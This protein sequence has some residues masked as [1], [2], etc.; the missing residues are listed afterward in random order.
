MTSKTRA[1]LATLCTLIAISFT[2]PTTTFAQDEEGTGDALAL[3]EA[4]NNDARRH[5]YQKAILKYKKV[6][7]LVPDQYPSVYYNLAEILRFQNTCSEAIILYRRY[8]EMVPKTRDKPQIT[9][10]IAGCSKTLKFARLTIT[11]EGDDYPLIHI[12]GIPMK[13]GKTIETDVSVGK[14][15]VYITAYD[16]ESYK[17]VISVGDDGLEHTAKLVEKLFHGELVLTA[18]VEGAEVYVDGEKVGATP[19]D[20]HKVKA[21]KR[22][23]TLR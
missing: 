2:L 10:A 8:L 1:F 23:S 16:Y 4:A 18:N 9:K 17:R 5:R 6:L 14:H 3:L 13:R 21:G 20:R 7:Q 12:D 22:F 11:A 19:V 15:E